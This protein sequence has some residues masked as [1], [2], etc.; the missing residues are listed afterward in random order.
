MTLAPAR[1]AVLLLAVASTA[2]G[3]QSPGARVPVVPDALLHRPIALR[4]GIGKAGQVED[5]QVALHARVR[6]GHAAG[7]PGREPRLVAD[8]KSTR[9]NS[10]HRT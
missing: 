4:P 8:R 5:H 9:L 10:S 2:A 7:R 1:L 3:A 6:L